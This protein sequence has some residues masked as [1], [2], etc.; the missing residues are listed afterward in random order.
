MSDTHA[1]VRNGIALLCLRSHLL[2]REKG[3]YD[4]APTIDRQLLLVV[5]EIVE[6]QDAL[7]SG[8]DA[9]DEWLRDDDLKPEGFTYEL[10]DAVIRICDLA[11]SLSLD[12]AGAI[13]RKHAFNAT[14]PPKHGRAF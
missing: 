4:P 5:S 14:R 1:A 11:A 12:L 3:F 2:A 13:E 8:R 7:R 6:A 10:A 9:H